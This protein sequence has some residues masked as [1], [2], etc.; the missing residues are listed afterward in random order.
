MN[1]DGK[2][3]II[4]TDKLPDGGSGQITNVQSGSKT[5][6]SDKNMVSEAVDVWAV[7]NIM[8]TLK[9][10][11]TREAMNQVSN[12]GNFTG[13]YITQQHINNSMSALSGLKS[14]GKAA[15]SGAL[16]GGAIG[17]VIGVSLATVDNLNKNIIETRNN[18]LSNNKQNYEISQLKNRTGLNSNI[19]WSRGTEN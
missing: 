17:A 6:I 14:I 9:H 7:N 15:V 3:Y 16:F 12:Y 1:S 4:V 13:D 19:N 2:I 5:N 10:I 8:S 11:A 18:I